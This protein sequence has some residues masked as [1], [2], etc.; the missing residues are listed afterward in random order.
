[1]SSDGGEGESLAALW[2]RWRR[3]GFD[4]SVVGLQDES[5][6]VATGGEGAA[7]EGGEVAQVPE[8]R[9]SSG[10]FLRRSM[11]LLQRVES[12]LA[13][14]EGEQDGRS[15]MSP[16]FSVRN[17]GS[18]EDV[19]RER[20]IEAD[21]AFARQLAEG[22]DGAGRSGG[23]DEET[24][25]DRVQFLKEAFFGAGVP[26]LIGGIIFLVKRADERE[27]SDGG[28]GFFLAGN[29]A[30]LLALLAV[31]WVATWERYDNERAL[32]RLEGVQ[33]FLILLGFANWVYAHVLLGMFYRSC[34]QAD[35][36]VMASGT[37]VIV[38]LEY[39]IFWWLAIV[40]LLIPFCCLCSPCL[41]RLYLY[42]ERPNWKGASKAAINKLPTA[43]FNA[44]DF[45]EKGFSTECSICLEQFEEGSTVR[46]LFCEHAFHRDCADHW[47][48]L[49]G[50]CPLCR[51]RLREN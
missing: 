43:K 20:Q 30:F 25:E 12:A 22:S 5:G 16:V 15:F 21:E 13:N 29:S 46:I 37:V 34:K 2:A 39:M 17:G 14:V 6:A 27:C 32:Q 38:L 26:L 24:R 44:S 47:L 8:R 36:G 10:T 18:G 42:L 45:M 7:R 40:A 49:N 11:L 23:M 3:G 35:S 50:T 19:E 31:L 51:E 28:F 33:L 48:K 1:M 41:Y 9:R 4:L